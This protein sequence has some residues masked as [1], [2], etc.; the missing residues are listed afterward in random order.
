MYGNDEMLIVNGVSANG[1]DGIVRVISLTDFDDPVL[2]GGYVYDDNP[3]TSIEG[4]NDDTD[5]IAFIGQEDSR[6]V[7]YDFDEDAESNFTVNLSG[8]KYEKISTFLYPDQIDYLT[9]GDPDSVFLGIDNFTVAINDDSDRLEADED[10]DDI[11]DFLPSEGYEI[12]CSANS[13]WSFSGWPVHPKTRYKVVDNPGETYNYIGYPYTHGYDVADVLDSHSDEI[14][15][16]YDDDGTYWLSDLDINTMGNMSPGDGYMVATD[17]DTAVTSYEFCYD[18]PPAER[19]APGSVWE[20]VEVDDAPEPT[21]VPYAVV[22]ELGNNIR[23]LEPAYIEVYDGNTLVGKGAFMPD[24]PYTPITCW[25]GDEERDLVG[26]DP[27]NRMRIVVKN[28]DNRELFSSFGDREYAFLEGP[29]T[30]ISFSRDQVDGGDG[31]NGFDVG[32]A[33]PSPFNPTLTVP[34][35][36]SKGG[37][38]EIRVYNLLGRTVFN[39]TQEYTAGTHRFHFDASRQSMELGSGAY[40]VEMR[41]GQEL[42]TQKVMLLK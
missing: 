20:V 17:T 24:R 23:L 16:V 7:I 1:E 33:Y 28:R 5:L 21:G 36:L 18:D 30:F 25:K 37:K 4:N 26:F 29:Y 35:R 12:K 40:F 32:D 3:A 11:G 41:F 13:S 6:L 27:G 15:A 38:V 31:N 14:D 19:R 42:R 9:T 10:P 39:S 22:V 8:S 2:V 34:F